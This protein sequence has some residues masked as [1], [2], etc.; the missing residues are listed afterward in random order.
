MIADISQSINHKLYR[1][2]LENVNPKTIILGPQK[3]RGYWSFLFEDK[4]E[5]QIF[6]DGAIAAKQFLFQLWHSK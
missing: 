2:E 3:R 4:K 1:Y 6:L 5:T